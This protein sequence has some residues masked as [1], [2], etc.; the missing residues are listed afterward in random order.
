MPSLGAAVQGFIMRAVQH[1]HSLATLRLL[2]RQL[3][4]VA[5]GCQSCRP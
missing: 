4:H 3:A 5:L 2:L 1:G